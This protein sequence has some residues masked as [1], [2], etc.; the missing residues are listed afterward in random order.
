MNEKDWAEKKAEE[1]VKKHATAPYTY[2][3][4]VLARVIADALRAERALYEVAFAECETWR[5]SRGAWYNGQYGLR[6][7]HGI[8][9]PH[10]SPVPVTEADAHDAAR[11]EMGL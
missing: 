2:G 7:W 4:V 3:A 9:S 6:G 5:A 1:I 10:H 8:P 11:K